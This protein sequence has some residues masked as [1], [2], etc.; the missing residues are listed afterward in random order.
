MNSNL[1]IDYKDLETIIKKLPLSELKK[2][3]NTIKNEIVTKKQASHI[4]L[5]KLILNAPTWSE[6]EYTNYLSA[7]N[8]I[9]KSRIA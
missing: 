5:Q 2:L 1:N 3:N 4:D 9:N 8:H 7:R 6:M